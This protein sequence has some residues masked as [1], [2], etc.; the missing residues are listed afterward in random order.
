MK[1]VRKAVT[2]F[3]GIVLAA[4]LMAALAPKAAHGLVATLVQVTNTSVD[5]VPNRDV[6]DRDR[7]TPEF[8]TC[9]A[10]TTAGANGEFNCSPF[11]A[12]PA[13]ER[14][15]IDEV[16]GSC[17]TPSGR[18]VSEVG[19]TFTAGGS[20]NTATFPLVAQGKDPDTGASTYNFN[21]AVHYIGDPGSGFS[22]Q[23]A[24]TD[25]TGFTG[26]GFNLSGHLVSYP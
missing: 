7:A 25:A 21:Q 19:L 5:P 8:V 3:G 15:V 11:F 22:W 4:L 6:D 23:A 18:S 13:G 26:C 1:I 24:T 16:D 17:A 9:F 2:A 14:F 10:G 20:A 12:V